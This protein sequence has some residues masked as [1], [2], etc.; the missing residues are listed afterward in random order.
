MPAAASSASTGPTAPRSC[1]VEPR[2]LAAPRLRRSR[3]GWPRPG[4]GRSRS[5]QRPS[6]Q[7]WSGSTRHRAAAS[8][9]A[10][11]ETVAQVRCQAARRAAR[12]Y[13]RCPGPCR[14]RRPDTA[15]C[16]GTRRSGS[17]SAS[18][19]HAPGR[20]CTTCR[21]A[22]RTTGVQSA[23][24]NTKAADDQWPDARRNWLH[25][26]PRGRK[27]PTAI[28]ALT[29]GGTRSRSTVKIKRH[30][31]HEELQLAGQL[32]GQ[33]DVAHVQRHD[34]VDDGGDKDRGEG[35]PAPAAYRDEDQRHDQVEA[36][37]DLQRPQARVDAGV[38]AGRRARRRCR[39]A[40][41][42]PAACWQQGS[43][44]SN[45]VR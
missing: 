15:A 4:H 39:I 45:A 16:P 32:S 20:R 24:Q 35:R 41:N 1:H 3:R 43:A 36:D 8:P 17:A 23:K 29:K 2:G 9:Q 25:H 30:A 33:P 44:A 13:R 28:A 26:G 18:T 12:Q 6:G 11:C 7:T 21:T 42:S 5:A 14:R 37:L 31:D 27:N 34:A 22:I 10:P 40:R 38:V 19:G